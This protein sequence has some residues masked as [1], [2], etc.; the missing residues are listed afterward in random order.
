MNDRH[1][2]RRARHRSSYRGAAAPSTKKVLEIPSDPKL[3]ELLGDYFVTGGR[4][5][6]VVREKIFEVRRESSYSTR[7]Q[8]PGETIVH[9]PVDIYTARYAEDEYGDV[10]SPPRGP[11]RSSRS[12]LRRT[13]PEYHDFDEPPY[14]ELHRRRRGATFNVSED[15]PRLSATRTYP[16]PST[17]RQSPPVRQRSRSQHRR[18][19]GPGDASVAESLSRAPSPVRSDGEEGMGTRVRRDSLPR[20]TI[21]IEDARRTSRRARISSRSP[22]RYED[23]SRS[24][25]PALDNVEYDSAQAQS[26]IIDLSSGLLRRGFAMYFVSDM[27]NLFNWTKIWTSRLGPGRIGVF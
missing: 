24:L 27:V 22:E 10:H 2:R 3:K 19:N 25:D 1:D 14:Y 8:R 15:E 16:R 4:N 20:Q 7:P 11:Y 5:G 6:E 26:A 13:R 12:R 18:S 9:E 23:V 17:R 21:T